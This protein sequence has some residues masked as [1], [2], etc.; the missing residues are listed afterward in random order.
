MKIIDLLES[1]DSKKFTLI[2][3]LDEFVP[4][5]A[6]KFKFKKFPSIKLALQIGDD[7]QPTF[8]RY[9]GE[10][11]II[12]LAIEHRHPLD[13]LRTLAHELTHYMQDTKNMLGPHSGETG[14][15][16]ENQ[17]NYMAGI[18]MREFNRAHPEFFNILPVLQSK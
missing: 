2:D 7:E 17:A 14:S 4:F 12:Q 10:E 13:I 18:I 9:I 6:G 3:V 5:V 15:R 8:G 16:E 11:G 1:K